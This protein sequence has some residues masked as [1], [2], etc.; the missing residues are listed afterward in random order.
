MVISGYD[1]FLSGNNVN[2]W[3]WGFHADENGNKNFAPSI[4]GSCHCSVN[5]S[6]WDDH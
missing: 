5:K 2:H 3:L 6:S 4:R 1:I